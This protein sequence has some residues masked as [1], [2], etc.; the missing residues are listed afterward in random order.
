MIRNST[1]E[2][3]V[4]FFLNFCA[5]NIYNIVFSVPCFLLTIF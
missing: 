5:N 3:T 1:Q 4:G 2:V